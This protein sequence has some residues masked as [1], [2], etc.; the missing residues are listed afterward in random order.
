L[1]ENI[2]PARTT[3]TTLDP[4][5]LDRW[6]PRAFDGSPI[7]A[8]DLRT[9]I[10]AA[11][12]APSANNYQPWRLLYSVNGDSNW[13]R[14]LSVLIPFNRGWAQNAGVMFFILSDTLMASPTGTEN[15]SRTHSFDAGAAWAQMALQATRMGLHAHGM[16]GLDFDLAR[17]ELGVPDRYRIEAAVVIG[18]RADAATLDE[19]LRAR[20]YPS[21]RKPIDEIAFAGNF[22][23]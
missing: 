3:D 16:A 23:A 18:K 8:T 15:P 4:L 20:E 22:P 5:F 10:D 14:F 12:W 21:D 9:I 1:L 17:T 7:S 6:S 13:E 19:R 2:V 11:R